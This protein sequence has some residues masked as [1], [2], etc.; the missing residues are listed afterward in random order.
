MF[1]SDRGGYVAMCKRY[2]TYEKH[3]GNFKTLVQKRREN[4]NVD[5]LVGAVNVWCWD[6]E[7]LALVSEMQK[8]GISRILWSNGETADII[9]AMNKLNILTSRYDI[10]QEVMN[11][12]NFPLLFRGF[13]LIGLLKLG[14]KK[15]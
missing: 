5:L 1:F 2:R 7:P 14:Q 15:I 10:Y 9:K 13:L 8:M 4:P 3:S 12:D 11:P 6:K